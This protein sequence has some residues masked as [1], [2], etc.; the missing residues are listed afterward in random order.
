[1]TNRIGEDARRNCR[2]I[3]AA[4][5]PDTCYHND[6]RSRYQNVQTASRRHD[7]NIIIVIHRVRTILLC[8][9]SAFR[10]SL[11]HIGIS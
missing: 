3:I 8:I 9:V 2:R 7:I 5:I 6:N 1:M 10:Q 11:M 4:S